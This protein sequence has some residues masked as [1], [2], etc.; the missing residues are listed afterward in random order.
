MRSTRNLILL[1]SVTKPIPR[2][3]GQRIPLGIYSKR[4]IMSNDDDYASFLEKA[5]QDTGSS[6]VQSSSFAQT[7]AVDTDVP[8]ALQ[9]LDDAFYMS[10]SDEPFEPVALKF[11]GKTLDERQ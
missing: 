2:L 8:A 10:E 7:K 5:N 3:F 11:G 9:S 1:R 6:S 4:S